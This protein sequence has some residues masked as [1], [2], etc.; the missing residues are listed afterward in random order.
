[1]N[2]LTKYK[3]HLSALIAFTLITCFYFPKLFYGFSSFV[4]TNDGRLLAWTLSWDI[5][6]LLT[7][8][9][10]IYQSNMFYPNEQTLTYSEHMIGTSF[11]GIPIWL[12]SNGNPA[13]TFNFIMIAGFVLNAYFTFLLIR[14]LVNNNGVAFFGAF[15]NGFCSYRL[16]NIGHL[17]NV[18]IFYIPLCLFLFYNFLDTKKSKYLIG[19][20]I[21]LLF[22]SLSSWY[23]MIFIFLLLSLVVIYYYFKDKRLSNKDLVKIAVTFATVFIFILPFAFP[24]FKQNK[25]NHT[26]Y[27]LNDII[28][29]DIGGYVLA[30]P[31]TFLNNINANYFGISKTR[32]LENF[33]YIGYVALFLSILCIVKIYRRDQPYFQ[34][35]K[36]ALLFLIIA[37]VFLILSLGPYLIVNDK[38]TSLKLPYYF[39]FKLFSPIQFLRT[40]SR[41]ATVVFLMISILASFGLFSL[42]KHFSNQSLRLLVYTLLIIISAVEFMPIER[43]NR[44]SDMSNVPSVYQRI[45]K[46]AA[47]KALIELP[48]DVD[49]F[50]TTKYLYYAGIHF[51]PIVNGYSGYEPPTY[52]SFKNTFAAPITEFSSFLMSSIGVTHVLCNPG[53]TKQV[54]PKFAQLVMESKGYKLYKLT[55]V[56][57]ATFYRES[58]SP[59]PKFNQ[60]D[61][62]ILHI[63]KSLKGVSVNPAN[64]QT[65][66]ANI[67]PNEINKRSTIM[68]TSDSPLNKLYLKFRVY[69]QTDTLQIECFKRQS[70]GQDSLLKK[71][72]FTN[73][74]Q[75]LKEYATLDLNKADKIQLTLYADVFPDRTF[76]N[77]LFFVRKN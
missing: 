31:Y 52:A 51:K 39:V 7:D 70:V 60:I 24:Y 47:V 8:P 13:A 69:S 62:S 76:I 73:N 72:T 53:Y 44:F 26:A 48:I 21:C 77:D 10:H 64:A 66:V 67:S 40:V 3:V 58:I 61:E 6:K 45:K 22:Q 25:E 50:T 55:P 11:L 5:H 74:S 54:D 28:S 46:D 49:P 75:F 35:R 63:K 15:L 23:H 29:G 9:F 17:Q 30:P 20:G 14:K 4:E 57:Q 27:L 56:K 65:L 1:M 33:N 32:W 59:W 71:Y 37:F 42:L 36:E 68:Y 43:F 12:I 2:Y 41:Y 16:W 38:T 19:I 34:F 18:V